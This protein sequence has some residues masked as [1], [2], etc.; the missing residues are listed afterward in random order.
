MT[1]IVTAFMM[2]SIIFGSDMRATPPS[3]R[4]SAGTRSRAMTAQAPASSA[5]LA[6]NQSV[7]LGKAT[8]ERNYEYLFSIHDIHD[9]ASL[10]HLREP[11]LDIEI[12]R[13]KSAVLARAVLKRFES[14]VDLTCNTSLLY[15]MQ[16]TSTAQ[17]SKT[18]SDFVPNK[19]NLSSFVSGP[20][21]RP[22]KVKTPTRTGDGQTMVE[23]D[24]CSQIKYVR[25][26]INKELEIVLS[27]KSM[28]LG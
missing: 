24:D 26:D 17:R 19:K 7:L 23:L 15:I 22:N 5:I 14:H 10:E 8:I 12:H 16:A 21:N 27:K 20:D 3:A 11:G 18:Q 2:P 9:D 13:P 1:G 6:W 4:I 25:S 28:T